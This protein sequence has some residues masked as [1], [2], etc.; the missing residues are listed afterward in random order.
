MVEY[1]N[2]SSD[3]EDVSS[4]SQ[5]GAASSAAAAAFAA[6]VIGRAAVARTAN[7]NVEE[8]AGSSSVAEDIDI[9]ET[10]SSAA[11]A[12]MARTTDSDVEQTT[13]AVAVTEDADIDET[14]SA[15]NTDA[16]Q[17]A[18]EFLQSSGLDPDQR[19]VVVDL[20]LQLVANV[21]LSAHLLFMHMDLTALVLD[22]VLVLVD[23]LRVRLKLLLV[24]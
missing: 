11:A 5:K 24:D 14:S 15:A 17:V 13:S 4:D 20:L 3:S 22:R 1:V 19:F 7:S 16:Q 9:D 21:G 18:S 6:G 10:A 2:S 8:S 23:L 12:A